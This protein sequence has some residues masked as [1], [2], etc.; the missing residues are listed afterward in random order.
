MNKLKCENSISLI[1]SFDTK[2]YFYIITDYYLM[3]LK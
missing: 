3:N 1:E 2:D